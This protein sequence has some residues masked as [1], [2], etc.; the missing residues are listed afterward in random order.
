M[1][2][3][4]VKVMADD[5]ARKAIVKP[6]PKVR[7]KH[8]ISIFEEALNQVTQPIRDI[9]DSQIKYID[10]RS[11]LVKGLEADRIRI[12]KDRAVLSS[13]TCKLVADI[14][15]KLRSEGTGVIDEFLEGKLPMPE[16]EEHAA[17]IEALTDQGAKIFDDIRYVELNGKLPSTIEAIPTQGLTGDVKAIHYEIRRLDDRIHKTNKKLIANRA[18]NPARISMWK[19]KIAFDEAHRN[20]LKHKLK[21]LQYEARAENEKR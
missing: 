1:K 3:N 15:A 20:D 18:K 21:K 19:E 9:V 8:S 16:L 17:K 11:D 13:H 5:A 6:L 14:E 10:E 12:L 7:V 2:I 4:V